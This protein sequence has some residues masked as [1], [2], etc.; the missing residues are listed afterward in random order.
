M[1]LNEHPFARGEVVVVG[2]EAMALRVTEMADI[3]EGAAMSPNVKM[4]TSPAKK[5]WATS[6]RWIVSVPRGGVSESASDEQADLPAPEEQAMLR[7][8]R[9]YARRTVAR[10]HARLSVGARRRCGRCGHD[11]RRRRAWGRTARGYE[12]AQIAA[13]VFIAPVDVGARVGRALDE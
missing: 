6:N 1:L 2:K 12:R 8:G 3:G 7:A 11:P 5:R 10:E 9:R 4:Y 13:A